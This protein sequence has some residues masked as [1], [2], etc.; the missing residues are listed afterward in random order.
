[1]IRSLKKKRKR[2]KLLDL[3][4]SGNLIMDKA[5][6]P[7]ADIM[8]SDLWEQQKKWKETVSEEIKNDF[9]EYYPGLQILF[10]MNID[11]YLDYKKAFSIFEEMRR[12]VHFISKIAIL[13]PR[14]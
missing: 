4:T 1:M 13:A 8:Y 3:I 7:N 10:S 6:H 9:S 11:E 5:A 2:Q 14:K 12:D